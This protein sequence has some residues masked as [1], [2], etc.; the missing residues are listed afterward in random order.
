M[1]GI[2]QTNIFR[3]PVIHNIQVFFAW[4]Y[5]ISNDSKYLH[6]MLRSPQKSLCVYNCANLN[7]FL[8]TSRTFWKFWTPNYISRYISVYFKYEKHFPTIWNL[9]FPSSKVFY[10]STHWTRIVQQENLLNLVFVSVKY[11][12]ISNTEKYLPRATSEQFLNF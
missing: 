9:L 2:K 10:F 8:E 6:N 7:M 3:S 5:I 11:C 4:I 1:K 12:M